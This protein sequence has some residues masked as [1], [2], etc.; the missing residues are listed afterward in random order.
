MLPQFLTE[1][2]MRERLAELGHHPEFGRELTDVAQDPDGVIARIAGPIGEETVRARYLVGSDGGRSFVRQ[3]LDI[4][5]PGET[6]GVRAVVADVA[7]EG[8]GRDAWHRFNVRSTGQDIMLCPLAGTDLF[9]VQAPIPL[10]G[11]VD[12]SAEGLTE[13]VATR[14]GRQ[15]IVIRSVS[16]ASAY[17]MNARLADRY[18]GRSRFPGG[19]CGPYS[20]AYRRPGSQY[21]RP[22]CLQSRLEADRRTGR[23]AGTPARD[24]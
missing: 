5:F 19:R 3:A 24:L 15:D 18:P 14:T 10:E 2:V 17:S 6:L 7:L 21:E 16:W 9:Q 12:L 8:L 1:G 13:M 11:D 23:R 4:G 22:G 20:S